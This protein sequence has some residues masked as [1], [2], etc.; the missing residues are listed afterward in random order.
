VVDG[1][2]LLGQDVAERQLQYGDGT[3]SKVIKY[4][5]GHE[6]LDTLDHFEA[7]M[8]VPEEAHQNEVGAHRYGAGH[9]DL[10]TIV[11]N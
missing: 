4:G 8:L 5:A 3:G 9:E 11:S 7:G 2:N 10:D 6:D 1:A